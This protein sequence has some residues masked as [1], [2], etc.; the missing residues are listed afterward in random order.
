[1]KNDGYNLYGIRYFNTGD[2]TTIDLLH[3]A[4]SA[5]YGQWYFGGEVTGNVLGWFNEVSQQIKFDESGAPFGG[6]EDL[7]SNAAGADYGDEY[8]N[9]KGSLADNII[10][11]FNKKYGGITKT[12]PDYGNQCK[13][14][15]SSSSD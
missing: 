13:G 2:G 14:T 11:Y 4:A 10:D 15:S 7:T 9:N 6:N 1:M 8:L 5:D 3:F 12:V